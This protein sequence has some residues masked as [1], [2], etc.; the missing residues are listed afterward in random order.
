MVGRSLC[1]KYVVRSSISSADKLSDFVETK[2]L[3][4]LQ[5][6]VI[7]EVVEGIQRA[8]VKRLQCL[9]VLRKL[10]LGCLA[11]LTVNITVDEG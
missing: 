7:F 6:L 1:A 5:V 8:T 2:E 10:E 4:K 11:P 9:P 3:K